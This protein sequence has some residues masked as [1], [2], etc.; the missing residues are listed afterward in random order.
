MKVKQ[1]NLIT[2]KNLSQYN[3]FFHG[4]SKESLNSS[5]GDIT[6]YH[7]Q[8][9]ETIFRENEQCNC[10]YCVIDGC[11]KFSTRNLK[12]KILTLNIV[13]KDEIMGEISFLEAMPHSADAITLTETTVMT[14]SLSNFLAFLQTETLATIRLAQLLVKRLRQANRLLQLRNEGSYLRLVGT[15]LLLGE[16]LGVTI[17]KKSIFLI[18]LAMN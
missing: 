4:F 17:E 5:L 15:L 11:V 8:R 6:I 12:E 18:F 7:Y 3:S 10:V 16:N 14:I 13:G 2:I 1:S 9:N